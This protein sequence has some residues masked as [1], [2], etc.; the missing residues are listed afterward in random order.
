MALVSHQMNL[1]ADISKSGVRMGA[2]VVAEVGARTVV[3][4]VV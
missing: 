4:V 2:R 3:E 1:G